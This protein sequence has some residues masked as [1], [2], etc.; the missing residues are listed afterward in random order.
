MRGARPIP[1]S[2]R[3]YLPTIAGDDSLVAKVA[4]CKTP[5]ARRV[6]G[7]T[8]IDNAMKTRD[9][10]RAAARHGGCLIPP[11][12]SVLVVEDDVDLAEILGEVLR[13]AGHVV[14]IAVDGCAGAVALA[15]ERP[16]VVLCDVQMPFGGGPAFVTW[17]RGRDDGSA[18]VPIILVSA[19]Q[20]LNAVAAGVGVRYWLAKPF[21][22]ATLV[23][24]VARVL[25]ETAGGGEAGAPPPLLQAART[26]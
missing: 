14:R 15:A 13:A 7:R 5:S 3:P 24:L 22:I 16:D 19:G 6:R 2:R 12:G 1:A 21:G 9:D 10:G 20:D 23:A 11:V 4:S 8:A 17:M 18:E 25:D 26:S